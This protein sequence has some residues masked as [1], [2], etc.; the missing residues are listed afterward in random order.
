[1]PLETIPQHELIM[2]VNSKAVLS[3]D[4]AVVC[5]ENDN[6]IL[7]MH[8][9]VLFVILSR[10]LLSTKT[11]LFLSIWPR[12][13][14]ERSATESFLASG[15]CLHG[16]YRDTCSPRAKVACRIMRLLDATKRAIRVL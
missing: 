1:M 6:V 8:P 15:R 9:Q 2:V 7:L 3:R 4:L 13:M 11:L 16:A 10:L 5:S 12:P 14:E